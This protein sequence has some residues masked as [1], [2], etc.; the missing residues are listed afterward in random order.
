MLATTT[1]MLLW[2][3]Q[4]RPVAPK[5]AWTGEMALTIKGE[6][7]VENGVIRATWRVDRSAKGKIHLD[8]TFKGGAALAGTENSKDTLRYESWVA[9]GPQTVDMQVN[10]SGSFYGPLFN[11]RNIRLD[12][13]RCICPAKG[14]PASRSQIRSSGLLLDHQKGTHTWETPR[15]I[16]QC[17]TLFLREFVKGPPAWTQQPPRHLRDTVELAYEMTS[18][19]GS[20]EFYRLSGPLPKGANEL[21]LSR[22]LTFQWPLQT[23][24]FKAPVEADLVLVLKRTN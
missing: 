7:K 24:D 23:E 3:L 14:A 5:P 16:T 11:P 21:V 13:Q 15:I 22:K 10:D 2:L 17:S 19:L 4:P 8:Q 6:G 9:D 18:D 20:G 1:L 12:T